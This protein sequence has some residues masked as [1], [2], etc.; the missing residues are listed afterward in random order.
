MVVDIL[1]SLLLGAAELLLGNHP[2]VF[3]DWESL[4]AGL[5]VEVFNFLQ[6]EYGKVHDLI[7]YVVY[8]KTF[9]L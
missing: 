9:F 3:G 4:P 6:V 2:A 7:H 5:L 1:L 8:N